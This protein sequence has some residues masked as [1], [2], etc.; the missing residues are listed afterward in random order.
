MRMTGNASV[1]GI[2]LTGQ[3][4]E[5]KVP[6]ITGTV[7]STDCITSISA[8]IYNGN[9]A[10]T[11]EVLTAEYKASNMQTTS[12][13]LASTPIGKL[14]LS[15]LKVG[16][17]YLT[18]TVNFGN[19]NPQ[20]KYFEYEFEVVKNEISQIIVP[21]SLEIMCGNSVTPQISV[22]PEGCEMTGLT[23][24][25]DHPSAALVTSA[26]VVT[27]LYDPYI[28]ETTLRITAKNGVTASV[29]VRITTNI[30]GESF[31][32][33]GQSISRIEVA[34]LFSLGQTVPFEYS[35]TLANDYNPGYTVSIRSESGV[36]VSADSAART[37]S[38]HEAGLARLTVDFPGP[39]A[40]LS[41]AVIVTDDTL[42][43]RLPNSLTH[44]ESSA[45]RGAKM[46]FFF[47]PAGVSYI[48]PDAFPDGSFIFLDTTAL[49]S[50]PTFAGGICLVETGSA[51]N[52]AVAAA[53]SPYYALRGVTLPAVWSDW[54]DWS[55]TPVSAD[56][57]T[58]VETCLQYRSAP[59]TTVQQLTAWS[60]WGSWSATKK[61]IS[62]STLMEQQTRTAY[63]YYY[64]QCSS[65]SAHMPYYGRGCLTNLGGCGKSDTVVQSSWHEGIWLPTTKA[66]CTSYNNGAKYYTTVNGAKYYY[67]SDSPT[68]SRTEYRYR[69]RS[70]KDVQQTGVFGA[71]TT[72]AI[73]PSDTLAV[74]TR[75]V[76]R[77]RTLI[78]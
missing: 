35:C 16:Y 21:S 37:I 50:T 54:S 46:R 10:E 43:A 22:L 36:A 19:S 65:C 5:G 44:I 40:S 42:T 60:A 41:A 62:N 77:F 64:F 7:S 55:E 23:Y 52:E 78:P 38:F 4:F 75:T 20:T 73:T 8:E 39:S 53:H 56:E 51:Y 13:S 24:T 61:T 45:F 28:S 12:V 76:Y 14:N 15:A 6:K 17:W 27:G 67:W 11:G 66:Q 58:Q 49:E 70:Y 68:A 74:E 59:I 25:V 69:T 31:R 57:V 34:D 26:G 63:P 32:L 9:S 48:S 72:E 3:F 71:W 2:P 1:S 18:L 30:T 33:N 47:L 29:P